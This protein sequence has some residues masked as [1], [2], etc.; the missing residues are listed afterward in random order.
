MRNSQTSRYKKVDYFIQQNG[1]GWEVIEFP[2]ND[3]IKTLYSKREAERLAT[4]IKTIKPFGN[5]I[6]PNYLKGNIDIV[7]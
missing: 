7:K 6:I 1:T 5:D 4:S 2:T 3:V